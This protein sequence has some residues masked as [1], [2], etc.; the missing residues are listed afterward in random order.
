MCAGGSRLVPGLDLERLAGV[1]QRPASQGFEGKLELREL[2]EENARLRRRQGS[3][4]RRLREATPTEFQ[5]Q[6]EE[7]IAQ[8][9]A[10]HA[11]E[12]AANRIK[13]EH[14]LQR[15][16]ARYEEQL[17]AVGGGRLLELESN[18]NAAYRA[19][20]DERQRAEKA[21]AEA[22]RYRRRARK[23]RMK[24]ME[25]LGSPQHTVR[26]L[27]APSPEPVS[28][29]QQALRLVLTAQFAATC[30]SVG[31]LVAIAAA[32]LRLSAFAAVRAWSA[33]VVEARHQRSLVQLN[34]CTTKSASTQD[35]MCSHGRIVRNRVFRVGT[36]VADARALLHV[37]VPF[38]AWARSRSSAHR[39]S[40]AAGFAARAAA[41]LAGPL[42]RRLLDAHGILALLEALRTWTRAVAASRHGAVLRAQLEEASL[43]SV[44]ALAALRAELRGLRQRGRQLGAAG[45][46]QRALACAAG[47]WAAWARA[48]AVERARKEARTVEELQ[49]TSY[50]IF[51]EQCVGPRAVEQLQ[52]AQ[53]EA[54]KARAVALDAARSEARASALARRLEVAVRRGEEAGALLATLKAWE[55]AA[56]TARQQLALQKALEEAD[57]RHQV[58]LA[59][60]RSEGR[61]VLYKAWGER[62]EATRKAAEWERR[63]ATADPNAPHPLE[64]SAVMTE[65]LRDVTSAGDAPRPSTALAVE[66]QLQLAEEEAHQRIKT[67]RRTATAAALGATLGAA[68]EEVM[69]NSR[70]EIVGGAEV[71]RLEDDGEGTCA[72]AATRLAAVRLPARRPMRLLLLDVMVAREEHCW[73]L[74]LLGAWRQVALEARYAAARCA[75][76][77]SKDFVQEAREGRKALFTSA[78]EQQARYWQADALSKWRQSALE[79]QLLQA[80]DRAAA[81]SGRSGSK[82]TGDASCRRSASS[83]QKGRRGSDTP[84]TSG[85][86]QGRAALGLAAD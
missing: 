58:A 21:E 26:P 7:E 9:V 55:S 60:A 33:V 53:L 2:R 59:R 18:L 11:R 76:T 84:K 61:T 17:E 50:L 62:A 73:E 64:L 5:R 72:A 86:L 51:E 42:L 63:C 10:R 6:Y 80:R 40:P 79:A 25:D 43:R 15:A 56:A 24:S 47:A 20:E 29:Q 38:A 83:P 37:A 30:P 14:E 69:A 49:A 75:S 19:C 78:L 35:S 54:A 23:L 68:S 57:R 27:S 65:V 28:P 67:A 39:S 45:L 13:H 1:L 12:V 66:R 3:L 77:R 31:R 44:A 41:D 36:L 22:A 85:A 32:R 81:S 34:G 71:L 48:A 16:I 74:G 52:A 4:E 70:P 8:R 82:A 46:Q